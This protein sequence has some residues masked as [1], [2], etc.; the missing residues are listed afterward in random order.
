M[1]RPARLSVLVAITALSAAAPA[2][3]DDSETA[4]ELFKRGRALFQ[5]NNHSEACP[6]FEQ[7]LALEPALG[8]ELNLALCWAATGKL[9]A[10]RR[11][12]E[13]IIAKT[14]DDPEQLKR[15]EIADEAI[16]GLSKRI[17]TLVIHLPAGASRPRVD[18][19]VVELT[20][21]LAVDPGP[22][23]VEADGAIRRDV[24]TKEGGQLVVDL[25]PT[26][27]NRQA[28]RSDDDH[29]VASWRRN[30]P[31]ILGA[32]GATLVAGALFT[33]VAVIGKKHEGLDHCSTTDGVLV[34]DDSG[35]A[36]L[37]SARS[38]SH[39]ATALFLG[40]IVLG[41]GAAASYFTGW[42]NGRSLTGWVGG[43]SAGLAIGGSF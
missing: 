29:R 13:G 2:A 23:V 36:S 40:G 43:K 4:R 12:F 32:A 42:S 10:A 14:A 30:A 9:V 11:M 35:T 18:D 19:R 20:G 16:A 3:A 37:A 38:L 26:A 21:P 33:G 41:G 22:H 6:L 15:R 31:F 24:V 1:H 17:P 8:T 28:N 39:V 5:A 27:A 34:C 25:E 7:S